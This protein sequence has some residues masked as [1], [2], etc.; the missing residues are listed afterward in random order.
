MAGYGYGI[1]VSGSR[2]LA[3]SVASAPLI[4]SDGLSL[5]L[6]ADAGVST[7]QAQYASQIVVSESG[8]PE[9]DG[10]YIASSEPDAEGVYNLSKEGSNAYIFYNGIYGSTFNLYSGDEPAT[11]TSENGATWGLGNVFPSSIVISNANVSGANGTYTGGYIGEGNYRYDKGTYYIIVY[12]ADTY[13]LY[14][15]DDTSLYGSPQYWGSLPVGAWYDIGAGGTC[16]GAVPTS[17]PALP[18]PTGVV[19]NTNIGP[20]TVT[21]WADQSGNGRNASQGSENLPT[22]G[23]I[24]GKSF[25]SFQ[26]NVALTVNSIWGGVQFVGTIFTVARF[27]SSIFAS[28]LLTQEGAEGNLA[29]ARKLNGTNAFSITTDDIDVV[30]SSS[31]ANDNTNYLLG[32][33]IGESLTAT[34][35][36]NSS[37]VGSGG[38]T[39]NTGYS[40]GTY[41]GGGN[42][43]SSIAEMIVYNRV[44]TTEERQQVEAYLNA[45]YA[46]Y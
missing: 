8:S 35:Y 21:E 45:K 38:I 34:L 23:L 32:A 40:F 19:T 2:T 12:P 7:S 26:S 20:V 30:T 33:T 22:Y 41:I 18:A 11:Y 44:L 39:N 29:F 14:G 9:F 24:G 25:I 15:P 3:Q 5:W 13:R 4:P 1:S 28:I 17:F 27:E 46:I 6:K 31:L 42:G 10:T 43:S 36:L 37:S 16:I